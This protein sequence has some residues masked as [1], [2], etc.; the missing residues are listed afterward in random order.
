MHRSA[1]VL[2][3]EADLDS[4]AITNA[5]VRYL[6]NTAMQVQAKT[7]VADGHHVDPPRLLWFT[8]YRD[9][10]R[11][12]PTPVRVDFRRPFRADQY[13]RIDAVDFDHG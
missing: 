12:G 11:H 2:G 6:A 9:E 8:V 7:A 3:V 13:V 10:H 4:N 5:S 1:V